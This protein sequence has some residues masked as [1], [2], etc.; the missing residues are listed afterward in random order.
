MTP[1]SE[2]LLSAQ[3]I[4]Y[5]FAVARLLHGA[6]GIF[7]LKK[8]SVLVII[9]WITCCLHVA[10]NLW[11]ITN[12]FE[13][14][15]DFFDF[16]LLFVYAGVAYFMC[17]TLTP[18]NSENIESVTDHFTSIRKRYWL[19]HISLCINMIFIFEYTARSRNV[20]TEEKILLFYVVVII[21]WMLISIFGLY[22][23]TKNLQLIA[24][25]IQLFLYLFNTF[26]VFLESSSIVGK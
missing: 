21:P 7:T 5:G 14:R 9:V 23:K 18:H 1:T 24:V 4:I 15:L 13:Q 2:L 6:P 25:S 8:S 17:D 19:C 16:L 10:L 3:T 20:V 11:T 26:F 12:I 22:A